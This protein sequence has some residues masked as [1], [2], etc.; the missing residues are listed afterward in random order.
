MLLRRLYYTA[1]PYLPYGLRL[2]LRRL[3]ARARM[4]FVKDIWPIN[5]AAGIKPEGWPGW[6]DGK[7]FAFV[8]T[9]DVEGQRGLDNVKRLAELEM[10]LG[11]RSSFNFIPEGEYRVPPE[12]RAWLTD[13]GFEVGVHDLHHDG[14]LF[15]SRDHFRRCAGHIN[16][17]L[18]D[19]GAV[20]F[21]SGFMLRNLDWLEELEIEYDASTFDTDPF[22]P[23]PE[24]A[25]TIFPFMVEARNGRKFVELPYT[26]PQDSTL[27]LILGHRDSQVW[28]SKLQWLAEVG[29]MALLN[30]HPDYLSWDDHRRRGGQYPVQVYQEFLS[31]A[32]GAC[33]GPCWQPTA[34][35]IARHC[36]RHLRQTRRPVSSRIA[37]LTH[38]F[39]ESD[40][41]V[42]RYAESLAQRH[43]DVEVLALRDKA[44]R[45]RSEWLEGVR[46]TRVQRRLSGES[47]GR[48]RQLLSVSVFGL[49]SSIILSWRHL[50][51]PYD[52]VHVHNIPDFLVFA[53]WLPKLTGT[54]I[55]LDFHDLVPEFYAAKFAGHRP[56]RAA[57]LLLKVERAS[58]RFA[59]HVIVSNHLW[60][61]K[62]AARSARLDRSSVFVNHV[63][64]RV[65]QR[66]PRARQ[67]SRFIALFPGGLQSH[68]GLDIAIRAFAKVISAVPQAEFHI[69]GNGPARAD[70]ERLAAGLGLNGKVQIHAPVSL[71]QIPHIMADADVGIVPKRAD[72]FGNEAYSTKIMEF[73][74]LGVPV[75]ISRTKIDQY[76]FNDDLVRFFESG[77]D[78]ELA[79]AIIDL[80][81]RPAERQRLAANATAHVA[82]NCWETRKAEYFNLV[83]RLTGIRSR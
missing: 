40:N 43:D 17:Y 42:M 25:R 54:P 73:M 13:H 62:V 11:F 49:R 69:Y 36:R 9:H 23:Q 83:D 61:E 21:R 77:N 31:F 75:I 55:I 15:S 56:S 2:A 32:A 80:H 12:L 67:D 20:G 47:A 60:R 26:L 59:D 16:R 66:H 57:R 29:G 74:A 41:R 58:A 45:R 10:R 8:L 44:D 1:K 7:Q 51:K 27:F 3:I 14:K 18:K 78:R 5:P 35:E 81:H 68:Q 34:R 19:W 38:S 4:P 76:Y 6:P 82:A 64:T 70:L 37:M 28:Q 22:E 39:Y 79:E 33:A 30:V 24:G 46:L 50:L 52:L 53:A 48:F 71:R 63:D 72:G 65:F